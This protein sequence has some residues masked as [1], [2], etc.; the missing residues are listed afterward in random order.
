MTR[1]EYLN[2]KYRPDIKLIK[3]L[4][5]GAAVVAAV[6]LVGVIHNLGILLW[7][8]VRLLGAG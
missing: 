7:T 2:L 5:V 3:V 6:I 4:W 8:V 1:F